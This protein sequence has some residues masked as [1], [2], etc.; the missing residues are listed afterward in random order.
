M[1]LE[2]WQYKSKSA[3]APPARLDRG[4]KLCSQKKSL[5]AIR[6][7]QQKLSLHKQDKIYWYALGNCYAMAGQDSMSMYAYKVGL[8]LFPTDVYLKHNLALSY[9]KSKDYQKSF[10]MMMEVV[11]ANPNAILP[12]FHLGQLYFLFANYQEA[13]NI[14]LRVERSLPEQYDVKQW[15]AKSSYYMKD[16]ASASTY[17]SLLP[18]YSQ[19]DMELSN[20][21]AHALMET[22]KFDKAMEVVSGDKSNARSDLSEFRNKLIQKLK[23]ARQPTSEATEGKKP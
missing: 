15:V 3:W 8:G 9:M 16:F 21:Y 23:A 11:K 2:S 13:R 4:F 10:P 14:F 22:G 7:W 20:L 6:E 19:K 5:Q 18:S 17:F 1:A 12:Q